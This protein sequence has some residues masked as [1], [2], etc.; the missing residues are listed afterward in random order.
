MREP[1]AFI[2]KARELRKEMSV[3]ERV[4][5]SALRGS[6]LD[7]LRFRRQHPMGPYVFDFFCA[8]AR[9][10]VEI[11]SYAHE[12]G[13]QPQRDAVRDGW[14]AE[15]GV[16]TLRIPARWVLQSVDGAISAIRADIQD[17]SPHRPFGPPPPQGEDLWLHDPPPVGE[18]PAKP[19]EGR[20]S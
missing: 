1:K 8:S 5:W 11:D 19:T 17:H 9:L 20:A 13:D 6:R 14:M 10:A 15:R 7:G 18:A 4:L 16:R 12:V 2:T 3:P